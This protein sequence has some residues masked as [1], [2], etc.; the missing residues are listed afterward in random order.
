MDYNVGYS[1]FN[2]T[3][4]IIYDAFSPVNYNVLARPERIE[5]NDRIS[6][7]GW[8]KDINYTHLEFNSQPPNY[9]RNPQSGAIMTIT[10]YPSE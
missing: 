1:V 7:V 4:K 10:V 9:I 5:A 2:K 8:K 6:Q 3:E